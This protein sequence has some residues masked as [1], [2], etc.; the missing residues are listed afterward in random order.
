MTSPPVTKPAI[1]FTITLSDSPTPTP[2][3]TPTP[4]PAVK[5]PIRS[6]TIVLKTADATSATTATTTAPTTTTTTTAAA[7]SPESLGVVGGKGNVTMTVCQR[8][9]SRTPQREFFF[10]PPYPPC[11]VARLSLLDDVVRAF[12]KRLLS[13]WLLVCSCM[14]LCSAPGWDPTPSHKAATTITT[15]NMS[16]FCTVEPLLRGPP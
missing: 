8:S 2:Q 15:T 6:G 7:A 16:A 9:R 4:T 5:P 10:L 3:P 13:L 11:G 14:V 1:G 12:W